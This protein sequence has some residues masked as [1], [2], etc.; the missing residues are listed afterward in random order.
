[1]VFIDDILIYSKSEEEHE[2]HL[3]LVLQTLRE[4][5]LYAKFSKCDFYQRQ[6]QYLGHI[7]SDQ[8]ISVDPKKIKAIM[9]WPTLELT[10]LLGLL[11]NSLGFILAS[12]SILFSSGSHVEVNTS[13][14]YHN[15]NTSS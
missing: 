6:I 4:H 2:E 5:Q 8:G 10:S 1:L 13:H 11:A 14:S 3:I 12:R 9:N 7:I 15:I